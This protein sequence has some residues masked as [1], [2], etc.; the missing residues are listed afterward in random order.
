MNFKEL[1]KRTKILILILILLIFKSAETKCQSKSDPL[2]YTNYHINVKYINYVFRDIALPLTLYIHPFGYWRLS[3]IY[4][5]HVIEEENNR[6]EIIYLK[7]KEAT[8]ENFIKKEYVYDTLNVDTLKSYFIHCYDEDSLIIK[9][10]SIPVSHFDDILTDFQYSYI[11]NKANISKIQGKQQEELRVVNFTK[12]EG[13][14]TINLCDLVSVRFYRDD[15]IMIHLTEIDICNLQNVNVRKI[16][17]SCLQQK[18]IEKLK[19]ILSLI[20]FD[21]YLCLSTGYRGS[22]KKNAFLLEHNNDVFLEYNSKSGYIGYFLNKSYRIDRNNNKL[23]RLNKLLN[24]Y[25]KK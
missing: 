14:L 6:S 13:Y 12:E 7:S 2:P 22:Y 9:N 24:S 18:D 20:E 25:K 10:A 1:M 3:D 4:Y 19:K 16:D 8:T 15:S 11:L 23:L 17:S 5:E 21:F